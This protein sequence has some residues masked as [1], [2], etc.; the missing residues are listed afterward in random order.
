[1]TSLDPAS[2]H[3]E[4]EV[5][6]RIAALEDLPRLE[7]YG[8]YA[9][10]RNLFQRAYREQVQGKRLMLVADCRGFP[11]GHV[12]MQF[13]TNNPLIADGKTRA[14]LY[15]FRV[16]E[17]FRG[18]G[19]GTLLLNESENLLKGR[20]FCY[21]TLAVGKDNARAMAL[22][23]RMGYRRIGEDAGRW[24]YTDHH[25]RLRFVNEPCWVLEKHLNM[26]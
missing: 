5:S 21:A 8:Q 3:I 25:G 10:F 23:E 12:F 16:M 2:L 18:K 6:L 13:Q 19:I 20:G 9:H 24:N 1:M 17:L 11:V 4:F 15:S 26:R 7:W 14:Y 22:Y